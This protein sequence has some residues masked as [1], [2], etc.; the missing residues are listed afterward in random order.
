LQFL[1]LAGTVIAWGIGDTL[2]VQ[3]GISRILMSMGREGHLPDIFSRIHPEYK[4]PYI[5]MIIV[6]FSSFFLLYIFTIQNL[7]SL[8]NFGA[9]TAFAIL[10]IALVYRFLTN[11][12]EP[13]ILAIVSGIG[14]VF[15]AAIW[16]GLQRS[17]TLLG[18][19]WLI[20]GGVYLAYI[21][22]GFQVK[23]RIPVEES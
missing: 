22:K 4:T 9:L 5:S 23:T 1:C 18:I 14:F 12:E 10:N 20:V 6:A 2:A 17:A 15:M 7:A 19:G 21:T 16:Y 3:A 13:S 11:D 8:V